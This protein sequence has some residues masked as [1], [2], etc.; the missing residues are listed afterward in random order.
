MKTR[1]IKADRS[2]ALP[3]LADGYYHLSYTVLINGDLATLSTDFDLI[4]WW[5]ND[6]KS[7]KLPEKINYL[8]AIFDGE[9]FKAKASFAMRDPIYPLIDQFSNGDWLVVNPRCYNRGDKN[10]MRIAPTGAIMSQF[11]LG[12][13]IEHVQINKHDEIIIGF[14]DEGTISNRGWDASGERA[15]VPIAPIICCDCNGM[16]LWSVDKEMEKFYI[17]D[18]YVLNVGKS[19]AYAYYDPD[20]NVIALSP[21]GITAH[22]QADIK[23]GKMLAF[24]QDY[25]VVACSYDDPNLIEIIAKNDAAKHYLAHMDSA[26]P[27]QAIGGRDDQLH[28]ICGDQWLT[29]CVTSIVNQL[30]EHQE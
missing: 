30:K 17:L 14:F 1:L 20:Y 10:A 5:R 28:Y 11:N 3:M 4:A 23:G 12:D 13:A 29:F 18:C 16:P 19:E 25:F 27:L 24:N 7:A 26:Q 22:W 8:I 2:V 21:Q 6:Q 15:K 9:T